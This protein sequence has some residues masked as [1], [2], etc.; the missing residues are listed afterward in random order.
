VSA[1]EVI[2]V[3]DPYDKSLVGTVPMANAGHVG[4]ATKH[5]ARLF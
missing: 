2:E 1:D 3:R 5:T 4:E